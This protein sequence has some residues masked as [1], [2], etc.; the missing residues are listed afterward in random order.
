MTKR[1][2]P[3]ENNDGF[4]RDTTT[5]AIINT[6]RKD[7][8]LYM[9][10]REKMLSDKQRIDNLEVK[11]SSIKDDIDDIKNLLLKIVDK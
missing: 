9:A 2:I 4:Y 7:Y 10:N 5:R 1:Y 8:Q 11:V 6:N 3:V